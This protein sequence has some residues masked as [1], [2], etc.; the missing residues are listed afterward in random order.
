M[1]A[2]SFDPKEFYLDGYVDAEAVAQNAHYA[3]LYVGVKSNP[4]ESGPVF[5]GS[6]D[7][8]SS[9]H[10]NLAVISGFEAAGDEAGLAAYVERTFTPDAVQGEITRFQN[11]P[12]GWAWLLQ[13]DRKLKDHGFDNL[14]PAATVF[15][16]A[17][18]TKAQELA[19]NSSDYGQHSDARWF[20]ANLYTWGK[21]NNR[22]DISNRAKD[23]FLENEDAQPVNAYTSID[24]GANTNNFWSNLGLSA[25]SHVAMGVTDTAKFETT[26]DRMLTSASDGSLDELIAK[27]TA[28]VASGRVGFSHFPGLLLTAAYGYWALFQETG[29]ITFGRAYDRIV[30]FAETYAAE[31]GADIGSGH[32]LPS[33][34]TFASALPMTMQAHMVNAVTANGTD[35]GDFYVGDVTNDTLNGG[36]GDDYLIGGAN[37]DTLSGG[38]G[39]DVLFGDA[40]T[41]PPIGIGMGISVQTLAQ[42]SGNTSAATALDLT[43][44]FSLD[45][46]PNIA[47]STV[48]PHT[49]VNATGDGNN[50]YYK[51]HVSGGTKIVVDIDGADKGSSDATSVLSSLILFDPLGNLLAFGGYGANDPGSTGTYD[52]AL[53]FEVPIDGEYMIGVGSLVGGIPAGGTYTLNVSVQG[54]DAAAVRQ[55]DGEAGNDL[56]NGGP[57]DD[58]LHGGGGEDVLDG[59]ADDDLLFGEAGNDRL[60]GGA[61][62]DHARSG[63]GSDTMFGGEGKDRLDG[64]GGNDLVKGD[65]G[66]DEL[67]GGDDDDSVLGGL[68]DDFGSGGRGNDT[69]LGGVGNDLLFGDDDD[70]RVDGNEGDDRVYGGTGT[71]TVFGSAGNDR[72]FGEAG[73]DTLDGGAG[74]DLLSGGDGLNTASY[75]SALTGL[76][77]ELGNAAANTGDAAGDRY[78]RISGLIGSDQ[79]DSLSGSAAADTVRGGAGNDT[80]SGLAG[81]DQLFGEDGDDLLLGGA[82]SDVLDGGVGSD[83]LIGGAGYDRL[84]GGAGADTFVLIVGDGGTSVDTLTDFTSGVDKLEVRLSG[85]IDSASAAGVTLT[86]GA[87]MRGNTPSPGLF[88]STS[89]GSLWWKPGGPTGGDTL[90]AMLSGN[91]TLTANDLVVV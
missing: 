72:L 23:I 32:W 1:A 90:L 15:A 74:A 65:T 26:Y 5:S 35:G 2:I 14:D 8:H 62:N 77:A 6:F 67:Y 87:M 41:A 28:D 83:R 63:I 91:P 30:D 45:N 20:L 38:E 80:L 54:R 71:D 48:N 42:G 46:D 4:Y 88:Y 52:A 9:V 70:D 84:T 78:S 25:Y 61:G 49:T 86:S 21:S 56:L 79:E 53:S 43:D 82:K 75:A 40:G 27:T 69:V 50:A 85:V 3:G 64:E 55:Y 66:D 60:I 31:L 36:K 59:G 37:D 44:R 51:I 12:Y 16:S 73:D 89:N 29:V 76:T 10:S 68:G 81:A 13:L 11:D 57:G 47:D 22:P 24:F 18:L 17:L 7:W 39:D 33:F 19:P 34:A 58:T